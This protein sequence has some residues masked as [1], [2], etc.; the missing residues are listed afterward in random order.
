MFF[1]CLRFLP[2]TFSGCHHIFLCLGV[3]MKS[4]QHKLLNYRSAVI[5]SSGSAVPVAKNKK[6]E[7]IQSSIQSVQTSP[8]SPSYMRQEIAIQSCRFADLCV[9]GN[10]NLWKFLVISACISVSI[11]VCKSESLS[12]ANLYHN[13][14]IT[15][16][17][18]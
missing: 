7:S 17:R 16:W 12:D 6:V 8:L 5:A 11:S 4:S 3:A 1:K 15:S 9:P 14:C 10:L 2:L 13:F 18:V